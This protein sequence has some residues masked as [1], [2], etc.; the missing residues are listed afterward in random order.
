MNLTM[1]LAEYFISSLGWFLAGIGST[2]LWK[3]AKSRVRPSS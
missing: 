1:S 3:E 2:C